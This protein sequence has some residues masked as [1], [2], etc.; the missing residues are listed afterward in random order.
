MTFI[1]LEYC[2]I[3]EYKA[4]SLHLIEA[5]N[6]SLSFII[7]A[8]STQTKVN[9]QTYTI[10]LVDTAGQDEYSIFPAQYSMDFHGYVLV[11]SITS[12]K[13]FEIIMVIYEKLL[14]IM[15]KAQ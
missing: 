13:S 2:I 3:Q 9:S 14:D 1:T 10:K 4:F 6:L 11:Y 7:L 12:R 8:F 15:G 5:H